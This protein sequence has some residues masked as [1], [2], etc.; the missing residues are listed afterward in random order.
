VFLNRAEK[1]KDVEVWPIALE[2]RLPEVA[3]PLL[4]GDP[5]ARLD[6]QA[7]LPTVYDILGYDE[8]IDYGKP[9]QGTFSDA[10]LKW[11]DEQLRRGGRRK[12]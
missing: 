3:V 4:P 6:L 12:G 5:D 2:S 10:E 8:M 7:A 1:R 9:P 11:V